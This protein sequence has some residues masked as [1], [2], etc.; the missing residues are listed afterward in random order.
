MI[1]AAVCCA[2]VASSLVGCGTAP[3]MSTDPGSYEPIQTG[4]YRPAEQARFVDCVFDGLVGS[5]NMAMS[6]HVRQTKRAEG[7]RIDVIA[8]AFQ[9]IVAD[10]GDDGRYTMTRSTNAKLVNFDKEQE[11]AR[12][13]LAAFGTVTMNAPPTDKSGN[14]PFHTGVGMTR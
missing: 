10:I 1:R 8:A 7:Y 5:Q 3:T 4:T 9:Y 11:A 14:Q 6:T 12:K 2:V 13:C